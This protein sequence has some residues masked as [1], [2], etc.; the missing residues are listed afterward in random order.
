LK[1]V[2]CNGFDEE[3]SVVSRNEEW[4]CNLIGGLEKTVDEETLIQV[5]EDCGRKCQFQSMIKKAKAIY[6]RSEDV[7]TFLTEFSQTYKHLHR[8]GNGNYIVYPKCYCERVNKM[9]PGQ[10]SSIYCNCSRGWAKALFEGALGRPV[11]VTLQKSII[12]GD[13]ECRFKIEL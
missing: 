10:L 3:S 1:S 7:D 8:E 6:M 2:E 4:I 12:A 13:N 5:L 9:P 11:Q